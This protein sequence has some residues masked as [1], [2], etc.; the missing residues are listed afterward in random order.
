MQPRRVIIDTDPGIDDAL[1]LILAFRSPE[2]KIEAI[3]TVAGNVPLKDATRN[4]VQ[5]LEVLDLSEPP[6]VARGAAQPLARIGRPGVGAELAGPRNRV[7]GPR[8]LSGP[9]VERPDITRC[10]GIAFGYPGRDDQEVLD[11]H[12]VIAG[13]VGVT[14]RIAG[15]PPPVNDRQKVDHSNGAIAVNVA[16]DCRLE[17]P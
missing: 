8:D 11:A 1:A 15:K 10:G 3:T 16:G 17:N 6:P 13:Q 14:R 4:A 9:H 5:V 7:E 12:Y 2:L